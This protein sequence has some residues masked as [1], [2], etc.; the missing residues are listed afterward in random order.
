LERY[1]LDFP[2]AFAFFHLSRAAAAI[3]ALAA[4]LNFRFFFTTPAGFPF[5]ALYSAHFYEQRQQ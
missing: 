1:S 5:S 2:S 4:A 3:L